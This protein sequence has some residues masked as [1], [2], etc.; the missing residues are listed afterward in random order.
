MSKTETHPVFDFYFEKTL[1]T[2]FITREVET[3]VTYAVGQQYDG[4]NWG[5]FQEFSSREEAE[6][7]RSKNFPFLA[8]DPEDRVRISRMEKVCIRTLCEENE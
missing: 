1:T 4:K 6:N 8:P 5:T 2:G 3:E 7:W